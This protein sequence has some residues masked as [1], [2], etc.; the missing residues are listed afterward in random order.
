MINFKYKLFYS[1][2]IKFK[3]LERRSEFDNEARDFKKSRE[4]KFQSQDLTRNGCGEFCGASFNKINDFLSSVQCFP[5]H[6]IIN[7]V[8][9]T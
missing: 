6:E 7:Y 1:V 2:L 5:I 9:K 3:E 8:K 4:F